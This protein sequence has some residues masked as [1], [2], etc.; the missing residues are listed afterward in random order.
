MNKPIKCITVEEA[1]K[2]QDNWVSTRAKIIDSNLGIVDSREV[3]Y[4]IEELEE[5]LAY[6]KEESQKQGINT[7]GIRVYFGAY[8]DSKSNYA[9]IFMA[10]TEGETESSNNNYN[11]E[12]FNFGQSGHPP[13]AY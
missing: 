9:T 13:K 3:H 1:R 2:L 12:P 11:I 5:Y 8:D 4:S 7:P 10:P 6:V